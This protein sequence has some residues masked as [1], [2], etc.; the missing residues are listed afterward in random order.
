MRFWIL[1]V[2]VSWRTKQLLLL[3]ILD[4]IKVGYGC[5]LC[6]YLG[7]CLCGEIKVI[8]LMVLTTN[9]HIERILYCEGSMGIINIMP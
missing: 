1:I 3:Y 9:I 5:I 2:S 4:G 8:G 7:F 6:H